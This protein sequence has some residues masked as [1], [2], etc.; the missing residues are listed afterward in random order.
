MP[1]I[2]IEESV[3]KQKR[4]QELVSLGMQ[5]R[6]QKDNSQWGIGDLSVEFCTLY[7]NG[8]L[9]TFARE[10]GVNKETMRRYRIVS[11]AWPPE[12][13]LAFLSHRHHQILAGRTDKIEWA[14]KA[15]DGEWSCELLEIKLKQADHKIDLD[16]IS[17][18][19]SFVRGDLERV[20]NWYNLAREKW[21]EKLTE[22]DNPIAD[23]IRE[24][25]KKFQN[26]QK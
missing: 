19:L 8:A 6:E 14:E 7:G 20:L 21:P 5:F 18:N 10:I 15:H 1:E 4:Y 13:R 2:V 22:E 16:F 17:V 3:T 11:E 26:V 24:K 12:K 23:K 9:D 25:L